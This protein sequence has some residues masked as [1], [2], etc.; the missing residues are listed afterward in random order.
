[1]NCKGPLLQLRSNNGP[2]DY[3]SQSAV[4]FGNMHLS[5]W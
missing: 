2:Y 1:M 4:K 5:N 3:Y